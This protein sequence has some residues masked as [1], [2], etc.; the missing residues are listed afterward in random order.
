MQTFPL[1][2]LGSRKLIV[3]AKYEGGPAWRC[4]WRSASCA[5]G[6]EH[7]RR[8]PNPGGHEAPM[9]I[10]LTFSLADPDW[11][12]ELD[13]ETVAFAMKA[14]CYNSSVSVGVREN[15][16]SDLPAAASAVRRNGDHLLGEYADI[17]RGRGGWSPDHDHCR[18]SSGFSGRTALRPAAMSTSGSWLLSDGNEL[19]PFAREEPK[20]EIN[21]D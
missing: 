11:P 21:T 1:T 6:R 15:V 9:L 2:E 16:P 4:R 8:V 19:P 7:W 20:V 17:P 13:P 5:A 12:D 10:V 18:P 3:D 14:K